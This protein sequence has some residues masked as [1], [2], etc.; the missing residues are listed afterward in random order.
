LL[1]KLKVFATIDIE[2]MQFTKD[3][4]T[5]DTKQRQ[6]L[7]ENVPAT[8]CGMIGLTKDFTTTE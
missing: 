4:L 1:V 7:P 2:K 5:Y 6:E 8:L 3:T